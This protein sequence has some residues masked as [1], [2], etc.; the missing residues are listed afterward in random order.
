MKPSYDE[1]KRKKSRI[2]FSDLFSAPITDLPRDAELKPQ[3]LPQIE[4]AMTQYYR[5]PTT[6]FQIAAT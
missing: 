4:D 6:E 5:M 2:A 3:I 1:K